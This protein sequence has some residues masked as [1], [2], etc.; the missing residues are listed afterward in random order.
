[1][2]SSSVQDLGVDAFKHSSLRNRLGEASRDFF[3][4]FEGMG[5]KGIACDGGILISEL[6][7]LAIIVNFLRSQCY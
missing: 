2:K 6:M 3:F 1:M 5:C 7:V 4:F